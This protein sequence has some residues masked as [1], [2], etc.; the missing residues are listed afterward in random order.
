[1]D[2]EIQ[3]LKAMMKKQIAIAEDTNEKVRSLYN[4]AQRAALIRFIYWAVIIGGTIWTLQKM[5]PYLAIFPQVMDAYKKIQ[6][7]GGL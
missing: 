3:E 7:Q 2:Q 5:Q 6:Q 4:S 1:M